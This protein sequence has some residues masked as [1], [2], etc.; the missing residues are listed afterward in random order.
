MSIC[1][2]ENV[3]NAQK[4]IYDNNLCLSVCLSIFRN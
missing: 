3:Y 1:I 2:L 4:Y